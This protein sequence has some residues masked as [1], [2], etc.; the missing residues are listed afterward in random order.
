MPSRPKLREIVATLEKLYGKPAPF[1]S[2]DPWE[3]ILRENASYLVDDATR[4]EVFRSLK[5]R[6]GVSPEAILDAPRAR[7]VEAIR[8]GGMRPPMRA[9]KLLDAAE[10]AREKGLADLRKLT[11][12]GGPEA[13]KVLKRFPGIGEPGADKLLLAAGSAVT[14]APDSNGLR[15]LVRLGYATEDANYAK[16]YRAVAEAVAPE[17]PDDTAWLV[18]AHQLLRRHGQET[19]RRSEPRC[20]ICPLAKGCDFARES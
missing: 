18:V 6:I 3:L 15:V 13:R 19:C 17:L 9:D 7:L 8:K 2:N 16:A 5:A 14:L 1:P 4:E 12:E 10:V 11:K 20:D